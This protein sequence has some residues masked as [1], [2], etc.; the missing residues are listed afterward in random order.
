MRELCYTPP[1]DVSAETQRSA[2]PPKRRA[3]HSGLQTTLASL[4]DGKRR[5]ESIAAAA[6]GDET[7]VR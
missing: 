6:D 3:Q 1:I 7:Y 5:F 4:G 2:C